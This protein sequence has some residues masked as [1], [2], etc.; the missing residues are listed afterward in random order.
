ATDSRV[1]L[2]YFRLF[3]RTEQGLETLRRV[4]PGSAGRNRTLNLAQFTEQVIPLPSLP[5]QRRIVA[6]IEEL[7]AKI[8]EARGLRR[9]AVEGARAVL[10]SAMHA[11]WSDQGSWESRPVGEIT[12]A[13]SGQVDPRIEPYA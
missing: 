3:F 9:E 2:N 12:V 13:S 5:E 11:L 7:A 1:D 6:R 4:S 8:E 10:D